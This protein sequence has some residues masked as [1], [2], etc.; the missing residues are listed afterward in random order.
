MTPKALTLLLLWCD[1]PK[2]EGWS[3]RAPALRQA[4]VAATAAH[5]AP[6]AP[7]P[8]HLRLPEPEHD[9][10][11]DAEPLEG[12]RA[13]GH[14][15]DDAPESYDALTG[16]LKYLKS[17]EWVLGTVLFAAG[18]Y[19]APAAP[20]PLPFSDD[21]ES[22]VVQSPL[23]EKQIRRDE[24]ALIS[25][26][27]QSRGP[28]CMDANGDE[29]RTRTV[30]RPC[31]QCQRATVERA[32]YCP[33]EQVLLARTTLFQYVSNF[34]FASDYIHWYGIQSWCPRASRRSGPQ[35]CQ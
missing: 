25:A 29:P 3:L 18:F 6:R 2:V 32:L 17:G 28:R 1:V 16:A 22:A 31:Q 12:L 7:T 5:D 15:D 33:L 23:S 24:R 27:T 8:A 14:H 11:E 4:R 9:D 19:F 26:E 20:S 10:A 35:D 13:P 30:Q 34:W 21:A